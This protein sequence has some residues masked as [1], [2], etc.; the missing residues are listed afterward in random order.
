MEVFLS[1]IV[2]LQKI[3]FCKPFIGR[4]MALGSML[5]RESTEGADAL[6]TLPLENKNIIDST[7]TIERKTKESK[8][9]RHS[10]QP[11]VKTETTL[12]K[13]KG[14]SKQKKK[15]KLMSSSDE[16]VIAKQ[17]SKETNDIW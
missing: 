15:F 17:N 7:T 2:S 8:T 5:M 1:N 11:S 14:K 13:A 10:K 12:E 4:Q 9:P 3:C 6:N 16:L